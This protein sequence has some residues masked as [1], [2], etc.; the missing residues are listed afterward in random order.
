MFARSTITLA[1]LAGLAT[2]TLADDTGWTSLFDGKTLDGW[3]VNGGT[4]KYAVEDGVI[5]GT[6]VEGSPNTFLCKG[7]YK[8]FVLELEVKCDPRLNS[9]VQVRSHVYPQGTPRAGVVFGPQCEVARKETGTAGRFYDEGRRGV[10]LAEIAEGTKA[11]FDDDGWNRYRI[12]VQGDRYRSWVNGEPA[13]DFTDGEDERGFIGLQVHGIPKGEG[14]YQVR[15]RNVRVRELKTG[16]EVAA[17]AKTVSLFN[18]KDLDGWYTFTAHADRSADPYADP[19][20]VYK[21]E[22]GVIH[23]SGEEFGCL[24]TKEEYGD[25]HLRLEVK[26]GDKKWPPRDAEATQR[27]SGILMHC[28]GPDQVWPKSIECQIQERDFGD[29]FM[30]GGTT[31]EVDGKTEGGRVARTKDVEKPHGEWNVVE[32]VCDGDSITNIV[33]G[34]G[35]NRGTKASVTRGKIVLQS[36]GAEVFF[37]NVTLTPLKP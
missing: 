31:L 24:T 9:G 11:A 4:A 34:V 28:V 3:K 7:D 13:S 16:E 26:W 10:W 14:P 20:G 30:V 6:T 35:V 8:D 18:G 25:Y 29:F 21:V 1:L 36:E 17:P 15:W 12:V 22:D 32:V 5:V 2:S 27:D 33:N 23:I 37:R 19:K